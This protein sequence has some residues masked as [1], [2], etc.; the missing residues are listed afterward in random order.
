[1]NDV[2][3]VSQFEDELNAQNTFIH[4]SVQNSKGRK[5]ITTCEGISTDIDLVRILSAIKK[6][7]CTNGHI[8]DHPERG[9]I[10][11][12]QGDQRE[13]IRQFLIQEGIAT[14]DN[15]KVHGY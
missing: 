7:F 8:K 13:N 2:F 9:K 3:F 5:H 12:V 14:D 4:L 15:I 11:Q 10:I 1:M 6:R